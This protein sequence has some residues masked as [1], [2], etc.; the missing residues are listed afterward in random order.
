MQVDCV[1][2]QRLACA[3]FQVRDDLM[4]KQ[5]VVDPGIRTAPFGAAP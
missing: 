2:V 5:V 4:A 3:G 1:A